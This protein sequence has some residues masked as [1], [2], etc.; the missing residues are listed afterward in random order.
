MSFATDYIGFTPSFIQFALSDVNYRFLLV[1]ECESRPSSNESPITVNHPRFCVGGHRAT[2]DP[3]NISI[4]ELQP[5]DPTKIEIPFGWEKVH[6]LIYVVET[7]TDPDGWQYRSSWPIVAL[8]SSDEQWSNQSTNANVCD[9]QDLII[10]YHDCFTGWKQ[11]T[12]NRSQ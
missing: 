9:V 10:L 12:L 5:L 11:T 7:N 6:Q 4:S 3:R 2:H 1:L 8:A